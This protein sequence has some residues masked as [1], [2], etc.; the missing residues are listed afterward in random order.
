MTRRFS[1]AQACA[2][3]FLL[4]LFLV[5]SAFAAVPPDAGQSLQQLQAP[6]PPAAPAAPAPTLD[7]ATPAPVSALADAT[8][9]P[10]RTLSISGNTVIAT[11]ELEALLADL[12]GST[13]T[14]AE[15]QAAMARITAFYRQRGY[16]LARAYLPPQEMRDGQLVVAVLEGKVHDVVADNRS[17]VAT[18]RVQR[19]LQRQLPP[20]APVRRAGVNRAMLLLQQTPGIGAVQGSLRP[21]GTVGS[22]TV[23]VK[24]EAQPL[25]SGY[26]GAD[27]HGNR[28]T[29][30][31]RL[32]GGVSLNSPL[33][34]GERVSL[35]GVVSEDD[36]LDHARL[37]W[38][39]PLGRNGLRIGTAFSNTR[40]ELG[41]TFAVLGATGTARTV[42]LYGNYPLLLAPLARLEGSLA[43]E[44]RDLHD[45]QASVGLD[46]RK[47]ADAAVLAVEGE[48]QDRG[49]GSHARNTW[50]LAGT[51]GRLDLETASTLALDA[52][53]AR[54]AGDYGKLAFALSREQQLAGPFSFYLATN[55]QYAHKN[56]DSSEQLVLGGANAVRA[57]PTGEAV[58]DEGWL[59]TAELRWRLAGNLRLDAFYDAG[60]V[61]TN[62]KPFIAAA[63]GRSIDGGGLAA[64]SRWKNFTLEG[65]LA[66]RGDA[67]P[68]SDGDRHP[69]GWVSGSYSF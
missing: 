64:A 54:T 32:Q 38:E 52:A 31:S 49:L 35:Q 25:V 41:E 17:R 7:A 8:P 66:W 42:S 9:I 33:G 57:Y 69:R 26:L 6:T 67:A 51:Y 50:R 1:G 12:P 18:A 3:A 4:G 13:R 65:S 37:G 5:P 63:N 22:T 60:H 29:G 55:G 24:T 15:L 11:T 14:L 45:E 61:E 21:G 20:G 19:M 62:R 23:N 16:L 53:T 46:S 40:Y 39:A 58:G 68:T 48:G 44:H 28:F 47:S 30:R 34:Y 56:L 36:L 10:V 43:L 27:N 59:A 2:P